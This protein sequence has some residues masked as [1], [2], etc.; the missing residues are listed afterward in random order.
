MI[1]NCNPQ[2]DMISCS[3][4]SFSAKHNKLY[5]VWFCIVV[6]HDNDVIMGATASQM[7]SLTIVYSTVYSGADKRIHQ[8][9]AS[10]A[11]VWAIHRWPANSPHEGPVTRKMLP[12]DDVI[13]AYFKCCHPSWLIPFINNC[14]TSSHKSTNLSWYQT[15]THNPIWFRAGIDCVRAK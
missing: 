11:F 7:T 5:Y 9:S 10:L 4:R 3:L 8:S 15:V 2:P 14:C 1:S 12:F 13:M 6:C